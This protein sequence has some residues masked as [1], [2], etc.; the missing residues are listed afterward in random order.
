MRRVLALS[1]L[2]CLLLPTGLLAQEEVWVPPK[3]EIFWSIRYQWYKADDHLLS[4]AVL[5]PELTPLEQLQGVD[6]DPAARDLGQM[7]SHRLPGN[8]EKPK[9]SYKQQ[10]AGE[11]NLQSRSMSKR[12]R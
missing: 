12:R 7:E 2:V 10:Q 4:R 1:V 11:A 5:K 8:G 9:I 3:G 6:F